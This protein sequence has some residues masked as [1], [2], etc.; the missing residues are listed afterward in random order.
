MLNLRTSRNRL[1]TSICLLLLTV[2]VTAGCSW[3]DGSGEPSGRTLDVPPRSHYALEF[4]GKDD[5]VVIP[6]VKTQRFTVE[7]RG[8]RK[9]HETLDA[10]ASMGNYGLGHLNWSVVGRLNKQDLQV[11]LQNPAGNDQL[12]ASNTSGEP[13]LAPALPSGEWVHAA[14]SFDGER[15]AFFSDGELVWTKNMP[16]FTPVTSDDTGVIGARVGLENHPGAFAYRHWL[17]GRVAELRVWDH[18]RTRTEIRED[19]NRY[20]SGRESGLVAYYPLVA[21]EGDTVAD[22][23]GTGDTGTIHG[24]RWV[25]GPDPSG[26]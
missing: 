25:P 8:Y 19:H 3:N 16:G 9:N 5:Y 6:N 17:G 2:G 22:Y 21:G 11:R 26:E 24:A 18:P 14:V 13:D 23:S 1:T 15:M 20:L 12:A 10:F 7:F 4:D